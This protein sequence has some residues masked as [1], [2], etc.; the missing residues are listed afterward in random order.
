MYL[1]FILINEIKILISSKKLL[2]WFESFITNMATAAGTSI[3]NIK[4]SLPENE[5]DPKT[6]PHGQEQ[7]SKYSDLPQTTYGGRSNPMNGRPMG[8]I[9]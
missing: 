6:S 7:S 2:D 1:D 4:C 5:T 3:N 8:I 9:G